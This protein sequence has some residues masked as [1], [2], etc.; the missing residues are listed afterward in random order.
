M[1][2]QLRERGIS[3]EIVDKI[4]PDSKELHLIYGAHACPV[5]PRRYIVYQTEI[6]GSHHFTGR[7]GRVI[8]GAA[9][10]WEYNADNLGAYR[11]AKTTVVPPSV[12]LVEPVT[13]DIDYLFYGWIESSP[14]RQRMIAELKRHIDL[15]V[16]TNLLGEP[17]WRL[18][19][20]AKVVINLHFYDSSP[21]E[22]FRITEALSHRCQVVSEGQ[23]MPGI[24]CSNTAAG[25]AR[26]AQSIKDFPLSD[27]SY[28][29]NSEALDRALGIV[30]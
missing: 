21:M 2:G 27:L 19:S 9:A 4:E 15:H 13:K 12:R 28:F 17:M 5:L 18:L 10:V 3:A 11:H 1:A 7:Y 24:Y 23:A 14:R 29:D 6:K 26:L 22:L 20:R 16:I 8:R 25:I 30:L